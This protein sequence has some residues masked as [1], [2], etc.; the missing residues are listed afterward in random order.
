MLVVMQLPFL[1][2]LFTITY[3]ATTKNTQASPNPSPKS[4]K[5]IAKDDFTVNGK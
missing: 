2:A 5:M 3:T 4:K 1:F